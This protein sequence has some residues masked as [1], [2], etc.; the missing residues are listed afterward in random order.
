[1]KSE[2]LLLKEIYL[3]PQNQ[4]TSVILTFISAAL[5]SWPEWR[6]IIYSVMLIILMLYRPQ[7]LFGNIELVNMNIFKRFKGGDK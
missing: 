1:M 4:I 7:G 6:M 5:A 2:P 3:I